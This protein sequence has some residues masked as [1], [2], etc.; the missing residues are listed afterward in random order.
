MCALPPPVLIGSARGGGGG[1]DDVGTLRL[2]E[3]PKATVDV[4]RSDGKVISR[5]RH[6]LGERAGHGERQRLHLT[7][8]LPVLRRR[9]VGGGVV[10][11]VSVQVV[12]V[13]RRAAAV[14][15]GDAPRQHDAVLALH[16]SQLEL[17]LLGGRG[18]G[19]LHG[20]AGGGLG[21]RR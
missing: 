10:H 4:P 11:V 16:P 13:H 5:S 2:A 18:L 6:K 12:A 3:K 7:Y 15:L 8:L 20:E 17:R 1:A 14:G 19:G 21:R 9:P